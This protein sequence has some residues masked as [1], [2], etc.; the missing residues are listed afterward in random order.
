MPFDGGRAEQ[1]LP[2][3][4]VSTLAQPASSVEGSQ[5]CSKTPES[6]YPPSWPQ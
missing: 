3:L 6:R 1:A 5:R 4:T 2:S